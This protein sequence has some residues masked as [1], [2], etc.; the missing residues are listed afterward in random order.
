M[1]NKGQYALCKRAC[2][3]TNIAMSAVG[4]LSPLLFVAFHNL[5]GISYTLLGTLVLINF[6]TQFAVDLIFA[7]FTKHFSLRTVIR[8][9]PL[10][11]IIGLVI[12]AVL[13]PLFPSMAYLFLAL[14]TVIFAASSGMNEVLIS[15]LIAAIPSDNPDA[16][17]SKLHSVYAW[18]VVLVVV[19][20]TLFL[21]V[22]GT[23]KWYF[24]ALIWAIVPLVAF[25][26][27][28][29]AELPPMHEEATQEQTEEKSKNYAFGLFLCVVCIFL[30]GATECAMAQWV[31]G[32]LESALRIPKIWGDVL[33]VAGFAFMLGLGR[34]LYAKKGK[35]ILNVLFISMLCASVCYLTAS[36]CP[37]TVIGLI[38]CALTGFCASMLWPGT[39]ILLGERFPKAGVTAYALMAGGGDFGASFAP[40]MMGAIVDGVGSSAWASKLSQKL[41]I[42]TEQIGMRTGMLISTIFP[43]LGI[44]VVC[45]MKKYF[46]TKEKRD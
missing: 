10:L 4:N 3:T 34:T 17:M 45:I 32:Y 40:Q 2:Y 6:C 30:G 8:I 5:F 38:A 46:K 25:I 21:W 14:G 20:S 36:L 41:S 37:N 22:F 1:K 31:S 27:F 16:E 42:S 35:N 13:P 43:V 39:L 26:L 24:L 15:P 12:Y 33:G 9:M 29:R 44:V 23:D 18:G 7:F 19:V 11:T 28:L